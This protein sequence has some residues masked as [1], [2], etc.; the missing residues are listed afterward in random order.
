MKILVVLFFCVFAPW[1]FAAGVRPDLPKPYLV[2][3]V[4]VDGRNLAEVWVFPRD[5]NKDFMVE[6]ASLLEALQPV[7]KEQNFKILK[8]LVRKDVLT[9]ANIEASGMKPFWNEANL[10]L[11]IAIPLNYRKAQD[12]SLTYVEVD[13]N[14]YFRPDKQSG[15]LNL[16]LSQPYQYGEGAPSN[17]HLPLVGRADLVENI[18]GFVLET[19]TEYPVSYTHLTLPTTCSV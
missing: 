2:A 8:A 3:P 16:R 5:I 4:V 14:K 12:L 17:S 7:L 15:Y 10:E 9:L 18:N 6:S 13:E 1:A 19:G 11:H